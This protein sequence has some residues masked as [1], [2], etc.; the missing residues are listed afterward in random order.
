MFFLPLYLGSQYY[1]TRFLV[2]QLTMPSSSSSVPTISPNFWI[3]KQSAYKLWQNVNAFV[4]DYT[5][6]HQHKLDSEWFATWYH[7][8][9]E[10][11]IGEKLRDFQ[12]VSYLLTKSPDATPLACFEVLCN[13]IPN[14]Q[15]YITVTDTLSSGNFWCSIQAYGFQTPTVTTHSPNRSKKAQFKP[16]LGRYD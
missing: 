12:M 13:L 5:S 10:V 1:P 16:K 7:Y 9:K 2:S 14:L 11:K 3:S 6:E 8:F 15:S 4:G